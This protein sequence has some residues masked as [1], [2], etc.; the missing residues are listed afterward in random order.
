MCYTCVSLSV[1]RQT[2][3]HIAVGVQ[4]ERVVEGRERLGAVIA[5][6][7]R[8]L[9]DKIAQDRVFREQRAVRIRAEHVFV[10]RTLGLVLAVVAVSGEHHAERGDLLAEIGLAG[11]V[12]EADDDHVA[13]LRGG[14]EHI[15]ADHALLCADGVH[16]DGADEV[17]LHAVPGLVVFAEHL[18][19]AADGEKGLFL[20]DRGADVLRLAGGKVA[21]QHLLLEVLT[22]ADEE[23]V[24]FVR[25]QRL[26]DRAFVDIDLDAAALEAA[27]H[28]D[29]VA[30]VA[31]QIKD[32]RVQ[33]ADIEFHFFRS[34]LFVERLDVG[35]FA[36]LAAQVEHGGVGRHDEGWRRVRADLTEQLFVVADKLDALGREARVLEAE[37]HVIRA[38][39]RDEDARKAALLRGER[40]EIDV[41]DPADVRAVREAVVEQEASL[42]LPTS[43][44]M[45]LMT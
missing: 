25:V 27:L 10:A 39:A 8:G 37:R 34:S 29:D 3:L 28:G 19:A 45:R 31:V 38:H 36:D 5:V 7:E 12:L 2:L 4:L 11:V 9:K 32:V 23:D 24:V 40:L 30:A 14:P 33:M 42:Q 35:M 16:A 22:A 6:V 41:P 44:E 26:A 1:V 13:A 15:V 17:E 20:L 21:Q 18:V 43:C